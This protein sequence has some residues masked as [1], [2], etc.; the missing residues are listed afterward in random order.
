MCD[1]KNRLLAEKAVGN[2]I[3]YNKAYKE[4][5]DLIK[6]NFDDILLKINTKLV[7][8]DIDI[9]DLTKVSELLSEF[10]FKNELEECD[11]LVHKKIHNLSNQNLDTISVTYKYLIIKDNYYKTSKD[12]LLIIYITDK[13][14]DIL[15]E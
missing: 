1:T 10:N 4:K 14:W 3:A 7:Q 2:L 13:K 12:I 11:V 9:S 6:S 5:K 15:L 8:S